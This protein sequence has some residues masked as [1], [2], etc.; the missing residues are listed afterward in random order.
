MSPQNPQKPTSGELERLAADFASM[1]KGRSL[2]EERT[3]LADPLLTLW[4]SLVEV[5]AEE[6]EKGTELPDPIVENAGEPGPESIKEAIANKDWTNLKAV[7]R[8]S[9]YIIAAF[10]KAFPDERQMPVKF[11]DAALTDEQREWYANEH[12]PWA[13]QILFDIVRKLPR[14]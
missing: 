2:E 7:G 12:E 6:L 11:T 3:E 1:S 8:S 13:M 10:K 5:L 9:E 4:P 14:T